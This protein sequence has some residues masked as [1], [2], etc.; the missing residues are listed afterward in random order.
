MNLEPAFGPLTTVISLELVSGRFS[1]STV[2][3]YV[4]TR[5]VA[6]WL[7]GEV[8][9]PGQTMATRMLATV[10]DDP[11][12]TEARTVAQ[13]VQ[14][15]REQEL[16]ADDDVASIALRGAAEDIARGYWKLK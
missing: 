16:M 2:S 10:G 13:I 1:E 8:G 3:A 5:T 4:D 7:R 12:G 6:K 9:V 11:E 15:L 14:Y